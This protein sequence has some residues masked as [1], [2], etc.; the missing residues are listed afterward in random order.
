MIHRSRVCRLHTKIGEHRVSLWR[1]RRRFRI[2]INCPRWRYWYNAEGLR[3]SLKFDSFGGPT[4]RVASHADR[5]HPFVTIRDRRRFL[6]TIGLLCPIY[7]GVATESHPPLVDLSGDGVGHPFFFSS[8]C[9]LRSFVLLPD[10]LYLLF[11]FSLFLFSVQ[12]V[13]SKVLRPLRGLA[14]RMVRWLAG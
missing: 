12:T 6:C 11:S 14:G 8:G 4:P 9:F 3:A 7:T 2:T 10:L 13:K 1:S 5:S